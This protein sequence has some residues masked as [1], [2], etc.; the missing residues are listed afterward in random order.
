MVSCLHVAA[1]G[2]L[3]TLCAGVGDAL[4]ELGFK[5]YDFQ[6]ASSRYGRD[7]PLW[8]EAAR[9]HQEDRPYNK[10]DFD[11]LVGDH[12]ALVGAPFS[13][14]DHEF[15]TLYPN[16]KVI[17]VT[18]DSNLDLAG[19]L[20]EK[21]TSRF[22]QRI[23]PVYFGDMNQFLMLN[24]KRDNYHCRNSDQVIRETV[25]EKNLLEIHN[26]IAWVPLCKF[27]DVKVPDA[28]APE[29]HDDT[30]KAELAARPQ[31]MV[32][33]KLK[34]ASRRFVVWLKHTSLMVSVA[35]ISA[36]A[37][38]LGA[39]GLPKLSSSSVWL[40]N[41]LAARSQVRDTTGLAAA[42]MMLLG[43]VCGIVAGYNLALM[44]IPNA[45]MLASSNREHL[46][47]GKNGRS[48]G[49][50]GRSKQSGNGENVRPERPTLDGWSGVQEDIRKDDAEM[51][52]QGRATFEEW[53]NSKHVTFHVTHKRTEGGQ[54]QFSG[55]RKILSITEETV[56]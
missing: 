48:W 19:K 45:A 2:I 10:S 46:R 18:R 39:V 14:F 32:S 22:W 20:L 8:L 26:S 23:D 24:A 5:V 43:F 55:P 6:A 27:L 56:E 31:R 13:F 3:L 4:K 42:G 29:L 34:K 33:E 11:K 25:R 17:L 50:Q 35:V 21:V 49:K 52:K 53:K 30:I 36:L 47:R 51:K 7:F 15:V 28:P 16:V 38:F 37:V 1:S 41:F 40:F 9:L 44:H 12:D 54:D